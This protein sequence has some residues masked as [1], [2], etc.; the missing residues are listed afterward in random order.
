[1]QADDIPSVRDLAVEL[2][3]NPN[4][5]MGN[6]EAPPK[7]ELIYNKRGIGYFVASGCQSQGG[8]LLRPALP[9]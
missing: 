1:M 2:E 9:R 8:G 7:E 4:T 5:A 6:F 3:V